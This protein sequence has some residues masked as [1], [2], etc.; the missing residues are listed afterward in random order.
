MHDIVSKILNESKPFEDTDFLPTLLGH[1]R[2]GVTKGSIP[3]VL[4][5]AGTAGIRLCMALE[6]HHV[7]ITC[8]CDNNP[9]T[10]GGHCSGY[11]VISVEEL[12]RSHQDS[13]IVITVS[14]QYTQQIHGQLLALGFS[15]DKIHTLPLDPMIYYTNVSKLYWYPADLQV[16]AQQLQDAHNL[17]ADKKSK[18]LFVNRI[19]LLTNGF[20][21]NS[22]RH[23]IDEFADFLSVHGPNLFSE[24]L[25]DENYFYF[26]S[27]FFPVKEGEVFAN[28]G[29]LLGD[30]AIE[31]AN[32][33]REKGLP[34]KEIINFEPDPS[35][36]ILLSKNMTHLPNVRC[37]P[38]GLWSHNSRLRFSNP[39]QSGAGAPGRLDNEGD[40]EV[41]VV[42]LDKLLPDADITLIKM[43]VEGAEMEALRGAADTIRRNTPKLAI[44]VYHERDDIF[45]IPLFI[46]QLHSGYKFYLRHHSTTFSETV[47]FAIP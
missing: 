29:A 21:Y 24:P 30:C 18:D 1:H 37:L 14:S 8:F 13:L 22:F 36:F 4:F 38:Y 41:D 17:F 3:V 26:H 33:C 9:E 23:F 28:V 46:H 16:H 47:L 7:N 39:A 35:N 10:V 42:S 27:D 15:S 40:L 45:E 2:N 32:A 20:D 25:Y 31:F 12:R 11:P 19:A 43:D 34:Y 44:S 5:G 6:I